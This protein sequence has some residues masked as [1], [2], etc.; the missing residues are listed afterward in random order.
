M[1]NEKAIEKFLDLM[2]EDETFTN[3]VCQA[4]Q[5]DE[6]QILAKEKGIDLTM[7]DIM[8]SKELISRAVDQLNE[9]ELSADELDQV[10]GGVVVTTSVLVGA[11]CISA[12][13]GIAGVLFTGGMGI[14]GATMQRWKW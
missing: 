11:A 13:A 14:L 8:A 6:V 1:L 12:A 9:S 10:A 3:K 4:I 7:D 2:Q 5:A